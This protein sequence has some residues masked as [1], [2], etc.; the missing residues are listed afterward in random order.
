MIEYAMMVGAAEF[1]IDRKSTLELLSR[2]EFVKRVSRELTDKGQ[3][4]Y[5]VN[6]GYGC[7]CYLSIR[8]M[9]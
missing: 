4:I 9:H 5:Y 7:S 8:I 6:A 3:R 1:I 2:T